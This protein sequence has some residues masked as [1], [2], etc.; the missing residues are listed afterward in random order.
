[1]HL[2][3][4]IPADAEQ[5]AAIYYHTIHTVNAAHYTAPQREAWAP[6]A[7]LD[8]TGW[9]LKQRDR[10]TLVAEREG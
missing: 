6:A 9:R 5:I 4:A 3:P 1:M 8:P 10:Y 2:R 7:T